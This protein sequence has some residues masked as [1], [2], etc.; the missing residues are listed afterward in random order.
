MF[1]YKRKYDNLDKAQ[2]FSTILQG[3]YDVLDLMAELFGLYPT[4]SPD[5][6]KEYQQFVKQTLKGQS[7]EE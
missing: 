3:H 4:E 7:P 2:L 1:D 5:T 6:N